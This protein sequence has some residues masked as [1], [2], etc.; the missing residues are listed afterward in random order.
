MRVKNKHF[1]QL[2]DYISHAYS[3]K[4]NLFPENFTS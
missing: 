4:N 2:V 1:L 3:L